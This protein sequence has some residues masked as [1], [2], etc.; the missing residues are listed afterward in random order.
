MYKTDLD[1]SSS[2]IGIWI[3]QGVCFIKFIALI[4]R[5][6][7]QN[8]LRDHDMAVLRGRNAEGFREREERRSG[9]DVAEHVNRDREHRCLEAHSGDETCQGDL[10]TLRA[11]R[12]QER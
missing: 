7:V 5:M 10:H 3:G 2:R 11:Q 12:A 1:S 6:H 4:M 8:V 9:S